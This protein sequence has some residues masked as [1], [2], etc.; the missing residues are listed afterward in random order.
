MTSLDPVTVTAPVPAPSLVGAG[1]SVA[2]RGVVKRFGAATAVAGVDLDVRS[3]EFLSLLGPSGCGKTTLLRMLAGFE[4]PDEGTIE[5]AGRSVVGVPAHRRPVNTV[6]QAYALFPHMSVAENVAYG[7]RQRRTPKADVRR[8]VGEAL[9]M[10][11]MSAFA[12]RAPAALSG[13]QQQRV[14]LARA[15]VNRPQVLLLDEPLSALDRKLREEMQVELKLLQT[16]LGTTFVFVTHDQ[17]E[18]LSMSDRIA[19][20]L[21]GRVQQ[22]GAPEDIYSEPVSAFVAGFIGKQNFL[23]ATVVQP[24]VLRCADATVSSTRAWSGPAAGGDVLAAIRP[25]AL[26][27]TAAEPRGGANVV[28]GTLAGV[29][30]LGDVVQRVVVTGSGLELIA[31][32][33]RGADAAVPAH[34]GSEVWLSFPPEQVHVF[35]A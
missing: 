31:R 1:G 35:P 3:G 5:I 27:V 19:V 30:H 28:R 11:R 4:E 26:T 17:E 32:A 22:L 8:R 33:P 2:L 7:L 18:A 6:F 21:D 13:G 14:A 34:V 16:S 29:A 10:V 9:E 15:L 12:T 20:M 25:E 23:P 24:G